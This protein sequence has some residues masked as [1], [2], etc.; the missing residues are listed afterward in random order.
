MSG[1]E[2]TVAVGDDT[3]AVLPATSAPDL[4]LAL[5][6]TPAIQE[7][8]GV[9]V[10]KRAGQL[11]DRQWVMFR[12]IFHTRMGIRH[13]SIPPIA[14]ETNTSCSDY[15]VRSGFS[16]NL[17][18]PTFQLGFPNSPRQTRPLPVADISAAIVQEEL[19]RLLS[20]ECTRETPP[21]VR[22][23]GREG[24]REEGWMV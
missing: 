10:E 15:S 20:Y 5:N 11:Q 1:C 12:I 14:A 2:I 9:T 13:D 21:D 17:T 16:Q 6:N 3:M 22:E 4:Q 23:G 7:V 19:Q 8:G 24:G 18:T